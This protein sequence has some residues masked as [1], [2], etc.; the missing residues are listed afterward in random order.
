MSLAQLTIENGSSALNF[1]TC[2]A[3]IA[4][5]RFRSC[6]INLSVPFA[7]RFLARASLVRNVRAEFS[8]LSSRRSRT[9]TASRY[10]PRKPSRA[11]SKTGT[12]RSQLSPVPVCSALASFRGVPARLRARLNFD[13]ATRVALKSQPAKTVLRGSFRARLANAWKTANVT[14]LA[15]VSLPSWR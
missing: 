5:P 11:R 1:K 4:A 15:S 8:Q 6:R 9:S 7:T 2:F 12:M 13:T 10:R 3:L 14:S